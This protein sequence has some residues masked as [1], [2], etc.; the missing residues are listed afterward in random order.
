M[1]YPGPC[2][3]TAAR[4][5]LEHR[6]VVKERYAL[7]QRR[8]RIG[9]SKRVPGQCPRARLWRE[10]IRAVYECPILVEL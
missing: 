10:R 6:I 4:G 9:E 1:L 3:A 2:D 5:S 8:A 7:D